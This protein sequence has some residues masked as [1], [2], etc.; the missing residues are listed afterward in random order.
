MLN[1]TFGAGM[2]LPVSVTVDQLQNVIEAF[3]LL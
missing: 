3:D 1:S 2:V